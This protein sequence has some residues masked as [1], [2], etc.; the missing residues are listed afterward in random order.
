MK[1]IHKSENQEVDVLKYLDRHS[2]KWITTEEIAYDLDISRVTVN[3]LVK[4]I[5]ARV[6]KNRNIDIEILQNKGIFFDSE[7]SVFIVDI[8]QSIYKNSL[9]YKLITALLNETIVSL[10]QFAINQFISLASIRRKISTINEILY[11]YN[12][13]IK[14]NR[15]V[16]D[17]QNVRSFLFKYYWEIH[18]GTTWPFVSIDKQK[19][20]SVSDKVS[21]NL[22]V[23]CSQV[24][25]EQIYYLLAI[26]RLRFK[27]NHIIE[28]KQEFL[29]RVEGNGLFLEAKKIWVQEFPFLNVSENELQYYFFIVSSFSLNYIRTDFDTLLSL[30][31]LYE[32]Q[33]TFSY[34]ITKKLFNQIEERYNKKNLEEK[35]PLLFLELLMYH[36]RAFTI[37]S[38][39]LI[40]SLDR[41]YFVG[42]M[43]HNYP[44]IFTRLTKTVNSITKEFPQMKQSKN[45]LLEIYSMF[46]FQAL[47]TFFLKK[48]KVFISITDGRSV[49]KM[50][51]HD[52]KQHFEDKF[53]IE[54]TAHEEEADLCITDS[55]FYHIRKSKILYI[56]EP[57][58]TERD[59]SYLENVFNNRYTTF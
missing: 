25:Y 44:E 37:A 35:Q 46:Y 16:G 32:K 7:S 15:I 9:T 13:I 5:Q 50:I 31:D 18:R 6:K 1:S 57:R 36:N 12:I 10:D 33:Q 40:T 14:N 49:E 52:I 29:D 56:I 27:K 24:S 42:K 19:L 20:V 26:A 2:R 55:E 41:C 21:T 28:Q 38:D 34:L 17:E 45:Y 8:I 23:W 39:M 3:K 59:F 54:E 30:K 43:R 48:F 4:S 53:I 22:N 51:F 11:D 47:R 58:L